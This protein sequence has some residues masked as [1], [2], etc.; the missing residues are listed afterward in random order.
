MAAKIKMDEAIKRFKSGQ[1]CMVVEYRSS[2]AERIRWRDKET[3]AVLEAPILR[4]T[5]EA[6]NGTPYIVNE[7]VDE[8]S[9]DETAYIAPFKK[10]EKVLLTFVSMAI[11][12]GIKHFGGALTLL[13]V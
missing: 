13:E 11:E 10:G 3:R 5:C 6:E 7:R 4:H 12:R 8:K 1:P 2:V 9:F